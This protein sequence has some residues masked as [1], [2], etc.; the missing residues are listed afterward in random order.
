MKVERDKRIG[1]GNNVKA[2]FAG[3]TADGK[4]KSA[5]GKDTDESPVVTGS[6]RQS[7]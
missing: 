2:E 3:Q 7:I 1:S 5:S 4:A 6:E